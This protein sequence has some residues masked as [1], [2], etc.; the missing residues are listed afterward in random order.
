MEIE[1]HFF[2]SAADV[3]FQWFYGRYGDVFYDSVDRAIGQLR[4]F[5]E[6]GPIYEDPVRRLVIHGTPLGLFYGIHG[7][8]I[9]IV[10]ILDLRQDP[11]SI[12]RRIG[13]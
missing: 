5:P 6:S 9:S 12:T 10:A 13:L 1:E 3:D 11:E 4:R 8:R 7:R 2:T